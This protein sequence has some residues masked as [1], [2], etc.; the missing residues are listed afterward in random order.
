MAYLPEDELKKKNQGT[1]AGT[2]GEGV[3]GEIRNDQAVLD[4]ASAAP[5][6]GGAPAAAQAAGKATAPEG[7]TMNLQKY[8]EQNRPQIQAMTQRVQGVVGKD[9][10]GAEEAIQ[11]KAKEYETG[12]QQQQQQ[13]TFGQTEQQKLADYLKSQEE[14]GKKAAEQARL[15]ENGPVVAAL[16]KKSYDPTIRTAAPTEAAQASSL[17]Q[18]PQQQTQTQEPA[19]AAQPPATPYNPLEDPAFLEKFRSAYTGGWTP[20]QFDQ[21]KQ[22]M[23]AQAAIDK[24]AKTAALA[25][26]E[27]GRMQL[28]SRLQRGGASKGALTLD[29]ALLSSD[30]ESYAALKGTAGQAAEL[31]PQLAAMKELQANKYKDIVAAIN[32]QKSDLQSQYDPTKMEEQLK[33]RATQKEKEFQ[34]ALD[35]FKAEQT[36]RYG[37]SQE[38]IG[39]SS[40]FDPMKEGGF[41]AMSVATPQELAR[42]KAL[43]D[44]IGQGQTT[45]MVYD[46]TLGGTAP[47]TGDLGKYFR[48]DEFL[49][50]VDQARKTREELERQRNYKA[51]EPE[52]SGSG[53]ETAA[54]I[55]G[56]ILWAVCFAPETEI[57]MED[58]SVKQINN[59][60]LG[61]QIKEGGTVYKI[62]TALLN[63][64]MFDYEGVI[65][66]GSHKVKENGIWKK[67]SDAEKAFNIG[68]H[69]KVVHN[70]CSINHRI[71]ANGIEFMD[72]VEV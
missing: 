16:P 47:T 27:G 41:T 9:I 71:I 6:A 38:G 13:Q 56:A 30:P 2:E 8:L 4:A 49:G 26:T 64:D 65:V 66:S 28:L 45:N 70:L 52:D 12:L 11:T 55:G 32:K 69:C 51:P 17:I 14:A 24:A 1:L 10:K 68:R 3:A 40:Y 20:E 72:D 31:D 43:N 60:V 34:D 46:P 42:M 58:G 15:A 50:A 5:V 67:V 21:A 7:S 44:L 22:S 53:W 57:E 59:I 33:S 19:P 62:S 63:E 48:R 36:A 23:E 35:A 37:A 25:G 61:D 29:Q 39:I 18:T 54:V